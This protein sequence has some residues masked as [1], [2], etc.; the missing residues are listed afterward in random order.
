MNNSLIFPAFINDFRKLFVEPTNKNY[1]FVLLQIAFKTS[2]VCFLTMDSVTAH[3][4]AH[5]KKFVFLESTNYSRF[6]KIYSGF[7]I[8][9]AFLSIGSDIVIQ[10]F[11]YDFPK[12]NF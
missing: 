4:I 8:F 9:A 7:Q 3:S 10:P 2:G 5:M 11:K 12:K 1:F 6:C